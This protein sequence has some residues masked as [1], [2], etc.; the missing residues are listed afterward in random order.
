MEQLEQYWSSNAAVMEQLG[1][2]WSTKEQ[3]GALL[4]TVVAWYL[5]IIILFSC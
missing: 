5:L 2:V 4:S 1:A 3:L